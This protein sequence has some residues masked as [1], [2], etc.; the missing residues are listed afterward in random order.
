VLTLSSPF[1]HVAVEPAEQLLVNTGT[2]RAGSCALIGM[3]D[4]GVS[5]NSQSAAG[6]AP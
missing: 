6:L 4:Q 3:D 5:G 1:G 2:Y